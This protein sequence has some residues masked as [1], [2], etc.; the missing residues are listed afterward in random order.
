M[1][2]T[3]VWIGRAFWSGAAL[4]LVSLVAFVTAVI[5]QAVGGRHE[6]TGVWGVFLVA[7]VVWI[8]NFVTL[9][10]LL[11]WRVLQE[12]NSREESSSRGS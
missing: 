11:A 10:A 6:A 12:T 2:N 5:L 1:R 9:V 4:T 3:Q 8:L 7:A